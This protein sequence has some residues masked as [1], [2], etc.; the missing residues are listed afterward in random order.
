MKQYRRDIIFAVLIFVVALLVRSFIAVPIWAGD[1]GFYMGDDGNY[2]WIA[3]SLVQHGVFGTEGV[4]TAYRMPLFPLFA[5]F[6]HRLFGRDRY[7]V[8][9]NQGQ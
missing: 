2:Y 7:I 3:I 9:T 1:L 5:A 6:W 4:P 8:G